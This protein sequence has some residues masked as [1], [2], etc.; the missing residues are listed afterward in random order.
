MYIH[1][2]E[3]YTKAETES[4][5]K[6]L[7]GVYDTWFKY[8]QLWSCILLPLDISFSPLCSCISVNWWQV[9]ELSATGHNRYQ[10]YI[11]FLKA[12]SQIHERKKP[13]E[14]TEQKD[15]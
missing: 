10:K 7:K 4:P 14:L 8:P 2:P 15:Y 6:Q 11:R 9:L 12:M 5:L 3:T 1:S 13:T